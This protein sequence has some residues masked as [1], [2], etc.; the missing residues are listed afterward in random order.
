MARFRFKFASVLKV[1]KS[2]EDAALRALGEAQRGYQQALSAK[3]ALQRELELAL[4]RR[5]SLADRPIGVEAF[6]LEHDF[7][8]GTK[9]RIVRQDQA[10]VRATRSVER[11]LRGYLQARRQT[12][13]MEVLYDKHLQEFRKQLARLEQR[14]LDDFSVMRSRLDSPATIVAPSALESEAAS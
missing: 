2:R 14:R 8:T 12:R 9:Q 11:A 6:R 4:I 7:I 13:A 3:Q 5:E 10:I 1:R